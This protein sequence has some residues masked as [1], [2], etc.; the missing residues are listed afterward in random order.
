MRPGPASNKSGRETQRNPKLEPTLSLCACVWINKDSLHSSHRTRERCTMSERKSISRREIHSYGKLVVAVRLLAA[1][2]RTDHTVLHEEG[3][4]LCSVRSERDRVS[5]RVRL[6]RG[7]RVVL[8]GGLIKPST[9]GLIE[10]PIRHTHRTSHHCRA[11]QCM[12]HDRSR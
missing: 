7:P 9:W 5:T 2:T 10:N 6:R 8:V 3:A 11:P 1:A 4:S 12:M